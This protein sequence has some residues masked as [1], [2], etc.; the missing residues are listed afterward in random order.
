MN[1]R[2]AGN[3]LDRRKDGILQKKAPEAENVLFGSYSSLYLRL[4]LDPVEEW[5]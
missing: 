1:L 5:F 2:N 4:V 3:Y